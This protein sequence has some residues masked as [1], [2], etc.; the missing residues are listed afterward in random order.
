[1]FVLHPVSSS[2]I[3]AV[4]YKADSRQMLVVLVGK[5]MFT[6]HD[7]DKSVFEALLAA[8]SKGQYF[9]AHVQ[10]CYRYDRPEPPA[11]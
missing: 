2:L 4:G 8:E 1:V 5:G 6:Y 9:N 10:Y 3:E 7:V 11:T